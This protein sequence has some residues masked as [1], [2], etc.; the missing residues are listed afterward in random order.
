MSYMDVIKVENQFEENSTKIWSVHAF[1]AFDIIS[2]F[3]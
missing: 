1:P 2:S 3:Q